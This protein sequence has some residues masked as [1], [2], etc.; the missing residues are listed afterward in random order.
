MVFT[1]NPMMDASKVV[2]MTASKAIGRI[3]EAVTMG[4]KGLSREFSWQPR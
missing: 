2:D 4:P 3:K 1:G